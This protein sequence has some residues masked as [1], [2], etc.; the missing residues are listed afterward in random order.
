ESL[1]VVEIGGRP[2]VGAKEMRAALILVAGALYEREPAL[3]EDLLQAG[4][5][6]MESEGDVRRGGADLQHLPGWHSE[7]R[8]PAVVVRIV[9]RNHRAERI[10]AAAQIQHH[11]IPPAAALR[12]REVRQEFRRR[13]RDRERGDASLDELT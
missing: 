3:I 11:Q 8:P 5:P 9:V 2:Q 4:E 6:R 12:A 13:E 7:R 10:V 1:R